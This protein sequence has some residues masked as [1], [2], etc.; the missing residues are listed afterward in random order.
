[1]RRFALLC[2]FL[3]VFVGCGNPPS[4]R[5]VEADEFARVVAEDAVQVVDVRTPSEYDEGHLVGA[6]NMDMQGEAFLEQIAT[7]NSEQPVALYCR[8]GRRSK[9][10]AEQVAAAGFEVVELDGGILSWQG[11]TVR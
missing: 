7:L 2:S 9:V 4:F 6:L 11:E 3:G 5:S 1:M 10:A 8:S